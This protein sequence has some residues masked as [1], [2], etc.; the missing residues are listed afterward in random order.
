MALKKCSKC[1]EWK[2]EKE[3]PWHI[4]LVKRHSA[5]SD[6]RKKYQADYYQRTKEIQLAYKSDRQ[7]DKREAARHYVFHY[8]QTHPCEHCGEADPYVLTFHHIK[9]LKKMNLSQMVNQGYS[10]DALQD[11]IDKCIV[12]C[13]NCH[14]REEK[15]KRGTN[16]WLF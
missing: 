3:F 4:T 5:C 13:A 8:L 12:L 9:G 11:E 10:F 6:C 16:Y 15:K 14:M 2:E 1:G 7:A